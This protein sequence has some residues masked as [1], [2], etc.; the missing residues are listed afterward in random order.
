[1]MMNNFNLER[2][3]PTDQFWDHMCARGFI[4]LNLYT[5]VIGNTIYMTDEPPENVEDFI[6]EKINSIVSNLN[7]EKLG[8]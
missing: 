7:I 2:N 8:Q 3:L 4:R 1:M 6:E 5:G